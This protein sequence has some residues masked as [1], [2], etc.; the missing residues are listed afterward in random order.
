MS[1]VPHPDQEPLVKRP[2]REE[3][4]GLDDQAERN[5]TGSQEPSGQGSN[6]PGFGTPTPDPAAP[7]LNP[8]P[9]N[10]RQTRH[11]FEIEPRGPMTDEARRQLEQNI[12]PH[13]NHP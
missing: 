8:P 2:A 10:L 7:E 5:R 6:T 12:V 13:E 4:L 3:H 9:R 1:H 11:D